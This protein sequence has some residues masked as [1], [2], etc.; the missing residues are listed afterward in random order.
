ML[1]GGLNYAHL[2]GVTAIRHCPANQFTYLMVSVYISVLLHSFVLMTD[3]EDEVVP[4]Y[5]IT[6]S[7]K[8]EL[9][10]RV[11]LRQ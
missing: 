2:I 7:P 10:I 8:D 9:H 5:G 1:K 3:S 6:T 11:K 4:K